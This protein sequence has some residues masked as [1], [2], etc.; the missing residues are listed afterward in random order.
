MFVFLP[1][2][3]C[4]GTTAG[5]GPAGI[6]LGKLGMG[7]GANPFGIVFLLRAIG[8]G[9]V[10]TFG[11]KGGVPLYTGGF[12]INGLGGTPGGTGSTFEPVC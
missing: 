4:N 10:I 6:G 9:G 1:G 5:I 11:G 8:R 3:I 12:G 2:R 7:P